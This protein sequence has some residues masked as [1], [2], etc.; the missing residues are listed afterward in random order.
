MSCNIF[1][2]TGQAILSDG[3][4]DSYLDFDGN[5]YYQMTPS[6]KDSSAKTA[7]P[8]FTDPGGAGD[9]L[10]SLSAYVFKSTTPYADSGFKVPVK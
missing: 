5:I 7:D 9:G 1:Y 2:G 10:L 3:V 8:Q 4:I 6:A